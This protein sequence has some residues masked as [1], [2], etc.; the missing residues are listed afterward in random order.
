[1]VSSNAMRIHEPFVFNMLIQDE[2]LSRKFITK[3]AWLYFFVLLSAP[4]GYIIRI[5]LTGSLTPGEVG[6][7]FGTISFLGLLWTYTDFW[8][9]ESLNYFL[10]KYIIKSDYARVKYLLRITLFVQLITST[11]VSIGLYFWASFLAD[12]YFHSSEAR[13][14]IEILSLFF[15]GSHILNVI[16]T[17]LNAIQN[18]KLQKILDFFRM[19]VTLASA[20][21]I[22]FSWTGSLHMYAWIWIIWIYAALILGIFLFYR[23]YYRIY[24]LIP[25]EKDLV[26]RK[27]LY[28]YSLGTL[29]SSNVAIVL[30]QVDMQFI[31]YFLWVS[32]TGIYAI[33][34][35]L[36]GI[37]FIFL[38]PI[39][40]FLFPVISEMG[41]RG[42][43]Q[44]IQSIYTIFSTHL[45]VIIG[46]M[47]ALFLVAGK[48]I[49]WLLFGPAFLPSWIALYYIAPF[50]IF[51][52]LFQIHFQILWW[53]GCVRKRITI[54]L[55][56]VGVSI[57]LSLICILGYKYGYLG[58]PSGSAAASFAVGASWILLWFL[59]YR[60]VR[61]YTLWFDWYY[62]WKNIICICLFILGWLVLKQWI[63][64]DSGNTGRLSYLPIIWFA[65]F[66]C[67]A[68]FLILNLRNIREFITTIQQVRKGN[69]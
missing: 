48:E 19:I 47:G 49:A 61:E 55:Y 35:S 2:S 46:W 30:H 56:A 42:D 51:N 8:L 20:A 69:L 44:K 41:W 68:I 52:V 26:L 16:N 66:S 10:P 1:M 17:F 34:L 12:H 67:F 4:I 38:G 24:F 5:I 62:F 43:K 13:W 28:R 32:D 9:T 37:P 27:E 6:I 65:L 11:I 31:T 45:S 64:L 14:V 25:S 29:F 7:I 63:F 39:I 23:S 18:V 54:L 53:L 57:V 50:L 21:I 3:W 22:L 40:G 59:S 60:A 33:Y 15:I 36:I 58:F